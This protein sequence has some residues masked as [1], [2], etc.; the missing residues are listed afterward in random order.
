MVVHKKRKVSKAVALTLTTSLATLPG[1]LG[2]SHAEQMNIVVPRQIDMYS[3]QQFQIADLSLDGRSYQASS[4][5]IQLLDD[6]EGKVTLHAPYAGT[7]TV[8]VYDNVDEQLV[9]ELRVSV[10]SH[11]NEA[12]VNGDGLIDIRKIIDYLKINPQ[13][14]INGDDQFNHNDIESM[15][16]WI[17]S[18]DAVPNQSPQ[19]PGPDHEERFWLEIPGDLGSPAIFEPYPI[20]LHDYFTEPDGHFVSFQIID[21]N[22][23]HI[24]QFQIIDDR[25]EYKTLDPRASTLD[26]VEVTVRA[27]DEIGAYVDGAFVIERNLP[28]QFTELVEEGEVELDYTYVYGPDLSEPLVLN[29]YDYFVEPNGEEIIFKYDSDDIYLG[30]GEIDQETGELTVQFLSGLN[31]FH[32]Y[33]AAEDPYGQA[34]QATFIVDMEIIYP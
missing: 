22:P 15:L 32:I 14:D 31:L 23:G 2:S 25:L 21:V 6:A 18:L 20:G 33:I 10:Q 16:S 11:R 1:M 24:A 9:E 4:N 27:T 13:P 12:D 19:F 7:Y 5:S 8:Y 28:P 3:G 34:E 17:D 30:L 26:S 29:L